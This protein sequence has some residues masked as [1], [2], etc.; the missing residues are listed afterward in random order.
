MGKSNISRM[1]G[2]DS[3]AQFQ[4]LQPGQPI[5]SNL[6]PLNANTILTGLNEVAEGLRQRNIFVVLVVVGGAFNTLIL[7]SRPTTS[8]VDFFCLTKTQNPVVSLITEVAGLASVA[9]LSGR[10]WLNNHTAVF[11]EVCH[12]VAIT[13]AFF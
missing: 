3:M 6:I 1:V 10:T 13:P 11:I 8:D 7:R 9:R 12:S 2:D 4:H 5:A